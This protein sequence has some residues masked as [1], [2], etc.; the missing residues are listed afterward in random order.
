MPNPS[1]NW[2]KRFLDR[3]W[4]DHIELLKMK[5]STLISRLMDKLSIK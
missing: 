2:L 4:P 1:D 5:I 3:W